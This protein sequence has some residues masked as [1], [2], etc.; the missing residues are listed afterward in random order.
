MK[1]D[2]QEV[3]ALLINYEIKKSVIRD[4]TIIGGDV[5]VVHKEES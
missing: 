5:V 1:D 2:R 4:L 3:S